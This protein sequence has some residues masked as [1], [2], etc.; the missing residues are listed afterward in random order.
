[1]KPI[2]IFRPGTL[3]DLC[4]TIPLICSLK[5]P[6]N[7]PI[8]LITENNKS[9]FLL[10]QLQTIFK[11]YT[12]VTIVTYKINSFTSIYNIFNKYSNHDFFIIPNRLNSVQ[13]YIRKS[14]FKLLSLIL[15][16]K[17]FYPSKIYYDFFTS[18]NK[19]NEYNRIKLFFKN[20][21]DLSKY[22]SFS[23]INR[24]V[25]HNNRINSNY[26]VIFYGAKFKSKIWP[27]SNYI[28]LIKNLS[29]R[30]EIH[31]YCMSTDV[32]I[33]QALEIY[34]CNN[35]YVYINDSLVNIFNKSKFA[36]Y[37]IGCDTGT[38]HLAALANTNI[39]CVYSDR[40][41][42]NWLPINSYKIFRHFTSCGGCMREFCI[43][44]DHICLSSIESNTIKY[45]IK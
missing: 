1:M 38:I 44:K 10:S 33:L 29:S 37:V 12:N 27:I 7:L 26:V 39:I 13:N 18:E 40:D 6:S 19:L 30:Y 9:D 34:K 5:N 42:D 14:K 32:E 8:L 23:L 36:K 43:D 2:A 15:G 41:R 45:F 31:F 20:F 17:L 25:N 3:G 28:N 35:L 21:I 16:V 22:N 4:C 24:D 11:Y